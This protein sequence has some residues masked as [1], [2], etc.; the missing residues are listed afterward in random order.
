VKHSNTKAERKTDKG[1]SLSQNQKSKGGFPV[2]RIGLIILA[3]LVFVLTACGGPSTPPATGDFSLTLDKGSISIVKGSS[4]DISI[5]VHKTGSFTDAVSFSVSNLP[6]GVTSSFNPPSSSDASV[7]TLTV[8]TTASPVS[9]KVITVSGT[10]GSKTHTANFNLTISNVPDTTNPTIVSTSPTN[11][12]HGLFS[13]TKITIRF[14]EPMDQLATQAAFQSPDIGPHT[15]SWQ[16]GGKTM[17]VTPNN[18]LKYSLNTAYKYY[19]FTINTTAKDK[20]GNN[21]TVAKTVKF[22]TLRTFYV[23]FI[24]EKSLDG[25]VW[26]NHV[27][28]PSKNYIQVGDYLFNRYSRGFLSFKPSQYLE[29]QGAVGISKAY[30]SAYQY[31]KVGNPYHDLKGGMI[32]RYLRIYHVDYGSALDAN[33]FT[34][35][36]LST[37][38][39]QF[40]NSSSAGFKKV[41]VT[42][43]LANDYRYRNQRAYRS[44]YRLQF[45]RNTDNDGHNDYVRFYSSDANVLKRPVLQVWYYRP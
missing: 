5:T 35:A 31:T 18:P 13:N 16:N 17:V 11:N 1:L 27:L 29:S 45:A 44:Q 38:P 36:P 6:G 25:H 20:A 22:T 3:A 14:S 39:Q 4:G 10:A 33:D 19:H 37:K 41:D 42:G 2:K 34:K 43:W 7:L 26:D 24:A 12:Q 40:S 30:V 15:F 23:Y 8:A 32:N 28:R 21:L 9:D